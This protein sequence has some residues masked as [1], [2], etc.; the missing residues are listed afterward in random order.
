M[1][2]AARAGLEPFDMAHPEEWEHCAQC[3]EFFLEALDIT[4][5]GKKSRCAPAT[6]QLAKALVALAQ[7]NNTPFETLLAALKP[8]ELARQY[9]FHRRDQSLIESAAAYLTALRTMALQLQRP[10]HRITRSFCVRT[11]ERDSEAATTGKKGGVSQ[12]CR[13]GSSRR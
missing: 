8:P 3:F 10:Q 4:D 7:L 1:M 12:Q 2:T 5:S 6:F 9:E 11:A 13:R